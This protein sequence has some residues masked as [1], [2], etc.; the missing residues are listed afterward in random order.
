MYTFDSLMK[1]PIFI[2]DSF[3]LRKTQLKLGLR[4]MEEQIKVSRFIFRNC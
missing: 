4:G 1:T 3:Y 2:S